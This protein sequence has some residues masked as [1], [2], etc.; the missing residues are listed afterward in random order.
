MS[1]LGRRV[2]DVISGFDGV[3]TGESAYLYSVTRVFVVP[4]GLK[5]GRPIDGVWFDVGQVKEANAYGV[6]VTGFGGAGS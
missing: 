6:R 3:V 1:L 4:H 5:D 2:K